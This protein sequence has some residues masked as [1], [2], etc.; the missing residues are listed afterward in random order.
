MKFNRATY[1]ALAMF[2]LA[3]A[4]AFSAS[5]T[6]TLDVSATVTGNCRF[7]TAG[8]TALTLANSGGAID[9]S[10]TIDATGSASVLFRC[11][12]G[13]DSAISA[14]DGLHFSGGSRRV[15]DGSA[16]Y[17]AYSLALTGTAQTGSGHGAGQ[18]MTLGINGTILAAAFQNAPAGSYT[19]TVVLDI[20]P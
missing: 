12:T 19:D 9:P 7:N 18:D 8:P 3:S 4:P 11:T 5:T 15:T 17:M 6:H 14:G 13:T 16:N 2:V 20:L 1:G 10:S